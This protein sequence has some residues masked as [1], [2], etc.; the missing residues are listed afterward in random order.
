MTHVNEIIQ[1]FGIVTDIFAVSALIYTVI[2][3]KFAQRKFEKSDMLIQLER[4][5]R[6]KIFQ[7]GIFILAVSILFRFIIENGEEFEVISESAINGIYIAHKVFLIIFA[8]MMIKT[9]TATKH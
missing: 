5:R 2:V 3:L 8:I 7:Q 1:F 4:K 9:T 6:D